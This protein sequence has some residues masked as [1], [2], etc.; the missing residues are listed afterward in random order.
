MEH[1]IASK[2]NIIAKGTPVSPGVVVG[3]ARIVK[4]HKDVNKVKMGDIMVVEKSN[5]AFA[6]GV[7]NASGLICELGGALTHICIVSMEMGIPC[8]A[9]ARDVIENLKDG[10]II[11]LNASEG[12]V[13]SD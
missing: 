11:T 3:R 2:K 9:G 13:Y 4:K 6:I 10:T 7:M 8:I 1:R 5:P 12:L